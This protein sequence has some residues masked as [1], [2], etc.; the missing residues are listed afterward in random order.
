MAKWANAICSMTMMINFEI[1]AFNWMH[2]RKIPT[3]FMSW[4]NAIIQTNE[5]PTFSLSSSCYQYWQVHQ[6]FQLI[7]DEFNCPLCYS[8]EQLIDPSTRSMPCPDARNYIMTSHLLVYH[9]VTGSRVTRAI[10]LQI[11]DVRVK[12]EPNFFLAQRNVM[13][14]QKIT[15]GGCFMMIAFFRT[16]KSSNI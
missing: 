5:H 10:M 9:I 3:A 7:R 8:R 12:S 4:P 14:Y 13:G 2:T 6:T 16:Q 11:H 1:A 15:F